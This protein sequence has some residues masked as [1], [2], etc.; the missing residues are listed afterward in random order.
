MM[1]LWLDDEPWMVQ[2]RLERLRA[3][4]VEVITC[5]NVNDAVQALETERTFDTVTA[6][7][8]LTTDDGKV[9]RNLGAAFAEAVR[10]HLSAARIAAF[11]SDLPTV[12]AAEAA[13]FDRAFSKSDFTTSNTLLPF[14][15]D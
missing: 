9:V 6:D 2:P 15:Q 1:A 12:D 14:V 7:L 11:S 4:G 3:S 5:T 13:I 8:M 10:K